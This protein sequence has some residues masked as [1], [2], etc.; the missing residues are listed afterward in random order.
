MPIWYEEGCQWDLTC[1]HRY[2][3]YVITELTA[4]PIVCIPFMICDFR[5]D[6]GFSDISQKEQITKAI[7]S[8]DGSIRFEYILNPIVTLIPCSLQMM[9]LSCFCY[10]QWHIDDR[11]HTRGRLRHETDWKSTGGI[12]VVA[13]GMHGKVGNGQCCC[14]ALGTGKQHRWESLKQ[15]LKDVR[16][17]LTDKFRNLKN[18]ESACATSKV[19]FV[20]R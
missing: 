7:K 12:F 5:A 17:F 15:D 4:T 8:L 3:W 9:L 19:C 1:I 2:S 20:L 18:D 16:L 13:M 11:C 14:Q 6:T 10:E